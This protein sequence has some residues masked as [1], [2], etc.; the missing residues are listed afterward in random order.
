MTFWKKKLEKK[1]QKN[2]VKKFFFS[3]QKKFF[4]W[5]MA[6]W[7]YGQMTIKTW[8]ELCPDFK[9]F[10]FKKKSYFIYLNYTFSHFQNLQN[11]SKKKKVCAASCIWTW[12]LL[13]A[14]P[15]LCLW[16]NQDCCKCT[17][18]P[19]IITTMKAFGSWDL[20]NMH[21][22]K[23]TIQKSISFF[24]PVT[25]VTTEVTTKVTTK[26]TTLVTAS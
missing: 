7:N 18:K 24:L 20:G 8:V 22:D 11:R 19:N 9:L 4:L 15:V 13:L 12:D 10:F 17:E 14:N 3:G 25:E 26:V 16:A 5:V 21:L 23:Y 6:H 1:S 2:G